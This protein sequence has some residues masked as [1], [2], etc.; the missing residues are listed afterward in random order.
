L[1]FLA[2]TVKPMI[3][4]AFRTNSDR[5]HTGIAGSSMGGL[6][7]LYAY[8]RHPELFGF[9]G[10]LSPAFWFGGY[11]IFGYIEHA[12]F[13][14]G[15]IY[16]DVGTREHG[17]SLPEILTLRARSRRTYGKVRHMKRLLVQKGFR[18]VHDLLHV[19][20]PRAIHNEAE[21]AKRFPTAVRFFLKN[22]T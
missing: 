2:Y 1:D 6:I 11:A 7:S 10:V 19:E 15:K 12:P 3:D 16:L 14:P 21:W 20:A 5:S 4:S 18:P 13:V 8:F 22:L 9:A 17:N